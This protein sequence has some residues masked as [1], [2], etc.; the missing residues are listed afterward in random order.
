MLL[1]AIRA[2][3]QL[4]SSTLLQRR[5]AS[6]VTTLGRSET[7]KYMTEHPTKFANR[8]ILTIDQITLIPG[9]K[10]KALVESTKD[11]KT[12]A[13]VEKK[14]K[15]LG[16]VTNRS[17]GELDTANLPEDFVNT[18]EKKGPEDLFFVQT[19]MN[20]TFFKVV[21]KRDSP[22]AGDEANAA[23]LRALRMEFL[24]QEESQTVA[25]AS[26]TAT[27]EGIYAKIMSDESTKQGAESKAPPKTAN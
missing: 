24:R 18:L 15:E 11:S 14:C 16:L 21:S 8:K 2:K 12:L 17:S 9:D 22:L 20:G 1:A 10:G 4:L 25:D 26:A 6:K 19:G 3:E 7:A 27:Y 5:L 13:E 23:A